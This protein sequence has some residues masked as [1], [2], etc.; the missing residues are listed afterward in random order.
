MNK[1][2]ETKYESDQI[3]TIVTDLK[4]GNYL[5]PGF[6]REYVWNIDKVIEFLNSI[7]NNEPFGYITLWDTDNKDVIDA[8]SGIFNIYLNE[9]Q[10]N[11]I[12]GSNK[13]IYY[14]IDGQQRLTTISILYHFDEISN[15]S[16]IKEFPNIKKIIDELV[17]DCDNWKFTKRKQIKNNNYVL[18]NHLFNDDSHIWDEKYKNLG[19][20]QMLS[21]KNKLSDILKKF[22][23][24][25]IG[26]IKLINYDLDKT[27][28]IFNN[29]NTKGQKLSIFEIINAKWQKIGI[30]LK[31]EIKELYDEVSQFNLIDL[32]DKKN[33]NEKYTLF[34]DCLY[35]ILNDSPI[36]SGT[37]KIKFQIDNKET[38][39][40]ILKKFKQTFKRTIEA[41]H[42]LN[43]NWKTLP[44]WNIIK[45]FSYFIYKND[46]N[47]P[48]YVDLEFIK[49]YI[50]YCCLNDRYSSSTN[51]KLKKDLQIFASRDNFN[52]KSF[53][54]FKIKKFTE[55]IINDVSY[56]NSNKSMKFKIIMHYYLNNF[57]DILLGIQKINPKS[58]NYHHIFP[59]SAK[60]KNNPKQTYQKMWP[61]IIN[62][63][64]NI[65]PIH[66]NS[67]KKISNKNTLEFITWLEKEISKDSVFNYD[68]YDLNKELLINEDFENF[69]KYRIKKLT[70][71][72]NEFFEI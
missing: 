30:N 55:D 5:I 10:L 52:E 19:N 27:I 11:G 13:N 17:F 32:D 35:L 16:W 29:M 58:I 66:E 72:I 50:V 53:N 40:K 39:E 63:I 34:I 65:I 62:N 49:K 44:S 69:I 26:I 22:E 51:E 31:N 21:F 9:K 70:K 56:S 57:N 18:P 45:W 46:N 14:I 3:Y 4:K 37:E 47:L 8:E 38:Y 48:N 59:K 64:A 71:K 36:L 68:K 20:D 60:S 28:E 1:N 15:Y 43:Y 33:S 23:K 6:Q 2:I 7:L 24:S 41:L 42:N 54:D 67:N 61:D 25:E 12:I